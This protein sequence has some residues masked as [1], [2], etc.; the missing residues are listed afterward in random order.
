MNWTKR[1]IALLVTLGMTAVVTVLRVTLVPYLQNMDTGAFNLSYTVVI[2]M[3]LTLVAVFVLLYLEREEMPALPVLKGEWVLPFAVTVIAVG[4]C[5][6]LTT[7]V[8]I[9]NWGAFGITPPP[10]KVAA[11]TVDRMALF[12]SMGLGVLAGVY[13]IRLG[14]AWLRQ[15]GEV[16]GLMPYW[17]L[18]P[19]FWIWARLARYEI[20]Y[21]S[22]VEVHE[23]FYDFAMLL[24]SMLFL[25]ALA[26]RLTTVNPKKP[27]VTL[28]LA[29]GTAFLS[30]SG[31][32]ARVILFLLGNG[33]A[34]RAGQL[35]GLSD[36]GV[37]LLAT[38]FSLYWL[39]SPPDEETEKAPA[40][41]EPIE[42]ETSDAAE[43]ISVQAE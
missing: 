43:E 8:D 41:V 6:L 13:Y 18:V 21:A 23:S 37:G 4:G 19:S 12:L 24:L 35:A 20:S 42:A 14:S 40:E 27:F 22:A 32:F 29:L 16:R 11:G 2:L 26:R 17:A 28:F 33:D 31:A 36:F 39:L 30:L 3:L 38:A 34:Y 15:K 25:F 5:I 7:L 9:Y 10:G 1:L